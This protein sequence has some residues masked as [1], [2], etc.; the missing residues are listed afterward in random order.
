MAF[1][2][3]TALATDVTVVGLSA[4]KAVVVIDR[5]G[6]RTISAG[7]KTAEGV[8]L[9]SVAGETATFEID[10]VRRVLR[11]GQHYAS[12]PSS[13]AQVILKAS[14][15]GHFVASGQ[16]NGGALRFMVDT[17]A[18]VVA[19]PAAD[20][21]R[22]GIDYLSAPRAQAHTANGVVSTYSVKLDTVTVGSI[23]LHNVE[24]MVLESSMP[25]ALLGMSFLGRTNLNREGELLTLTKRF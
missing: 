10:G 3:P 2:A 17:G 6:P 11:M 12:T 22:L 19:I 7:Q 23:T 13:A 25:M 8:T 9:L 20:A 5:A 14:D 16:V 18:S 24:A 1:I 4:N 21:R 15:G